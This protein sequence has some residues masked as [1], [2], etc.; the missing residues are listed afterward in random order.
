MQAVAEPLSRKNIRNITM[1]LREIIGL[2]QEPFFPIVEFIEWVLGDPKND[3]DFEIVDSD[4]MD[5]YGTTNTIT[6]I[7]KIR[8]D[9][10]EGAVK[11]NPRD[12][13]TLCHELGHFILHQPEYISFARTDECPAYKNPEWQAN[14]FAAELMAPYSIVRGWTAE[15]ISEKCGMSMQAAEIQ[16]KTYGRC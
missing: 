16:R 15:T 3:F 7:M 5:E 6:N 10:Y 11:G 13:F 4:R 2:E 9:V 14:V 8:S 12:R 1:K